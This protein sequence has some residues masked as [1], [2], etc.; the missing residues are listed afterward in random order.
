MSKPKALILT[1]YGIN[2]EEETA[3]SFEI[4]GAQTKIIHINDL[5]ES[6]KQLNDYQILAIPGG[7]S[8][9]DDTGAGNALANKIKNNL[10]SEILAFAQKD[11]LII[12]ICNGFQV[13]ANTGLAPATN[14]QYGKQEVA[15]MH[16]TTARYECRWV[17]LKNTSKKCIWTKGIDL[18]HVPIAHGEGNFY[19]EPDILKQIKQNDQIVFKYTKPD[20]SPAKNEFPYNPNGAMEDIAAICDESGRILGIMPHPER[21]YS[22]TNAPDWPLKK[23]E[24]IRAGKP[25]PKQGKG[26]KLFENAVKYFTCK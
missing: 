2:C 13:L 17:N 4:S 20:G 1:G 9:G 10:K 23:E 24:L 11:K 5:I 26:L 25:L 15:L 7:F 6:P 19:A 16:N 21:F 3:K 22:F 12:G 18:L 14:N 8:Y